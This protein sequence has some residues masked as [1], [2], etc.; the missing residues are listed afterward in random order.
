M[1]SRLATHTAESRQQ[2]CRI[3]NHDWTMTQKTAAVV[4]HKLQALLRARLE[5][6]ARLDGSS[7]C[8]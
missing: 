3:F 2:C 1:R 4:T 7:Y 5:N 8:C 6:E